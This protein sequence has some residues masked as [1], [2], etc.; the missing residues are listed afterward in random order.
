MSE[1][2]TPEP[3]AGDIVVR[4]RERAMLAASVWGDRQTGHIMEYAADTIERLRYQLA[5]AVIER[6][7]LANYQCESGATI[8]MPAETSTPR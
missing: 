4:L 5:Q 3:I 1:R 8:V 2:D 6:G 7:S